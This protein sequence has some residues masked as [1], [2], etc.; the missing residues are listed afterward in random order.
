MTAQLEHF[1]RYP[2]DYRDDDRDCGAP[3]RL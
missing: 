2:T 1:P 3:W